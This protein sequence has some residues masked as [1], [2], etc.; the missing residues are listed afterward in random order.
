MKHQKTEFFS[1]KVLDFLSKCNRS[2]IVI[3]LNL[4]NQRQKRKT[5]ENSNETKESKRFKIHFFL[6]YIPILAKK[7]SNWNIKICLYWKKINSLLLFTPLSV[8]KT[9]EASRFNKKKNRKFGKFLK[10]EEFFRKCSEN[11][12]EKAT[13]IKLNH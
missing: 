10:P 3:I 6:H 8:K 12:F 5:V 9:F 7:M 13:K 4:S 2:V 1:F 11:K